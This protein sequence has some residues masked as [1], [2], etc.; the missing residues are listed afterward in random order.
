MSLFDS[1]T[2]VKVQE[3]TPQTPSLFDSITSVRQRDEDEYE[4]DLV[5]PENFSVSALAGSDDY[6]TKVR[7]Y[8]GN[9]LGEGGQQK[10]GEENKDYIERFLSHMR[11]FENNTIDL[12]QEMSYIY[13]ANDQERK[14]FA[15]AYDIYNSLPGMFSAGGGSVLSGLYDYTTLNVFDPANVVGLGVGTLAAKQ[16]AKQGVKGVLKGLAKRGNRYFNAGTVAGAAADGVVSAGMDA[17]LQNVM[18]ESGIQ[19]EYSAG[20]TA[21]AFGLGAVGSQAAQSGL[22]AVGSGLRAAT[23][24]ARTG[25]ASTANRDLQQE[26]QAARGDVTKKQKQQAKK[27][28]ETAKFEYDKARKLLDDIVETRYFDDELDPLPTLREQPGETSATAGFTP[29]LSLEATEVITNVV[30]KIASET[31]RPLPGGPEVQIS[32][33]IF[34]ALQVDPI[35]DK[36][37]DLS[38]LDTSIIER[39]ISEA[40]MSP[41]EFAQVMRVSV[42]DAG[43]TLQK[44]SALAQRLKDIGGLTG[45]QASRIDKWFDVNK[46]R[47]QDALNPYQR[48]DRETRAF[49]VSGVATTVRNASTTG[50]MGSLEAG[51]RLVDGYVFA[52]F[53]ASNRESLTGQKFEYDHGEIVRDTFGMFA[54]L[55][56]RNFT[57]QV[58]EATL[59]D[60]PRLLNQIQRSLTEIG[61]GELSKVSRV[62]NFLNTAHDSIVRRAVYTDSLDRNLRKTTGMDIAQTMAQN[63]RIPTKILQIAVDDALGATFAD[64]P[65]SGLAKAFVQMQEKLGFAPG[66]IAAPLTGNPM[67]ALAGTTITA[68][69]RFMVSALKMI[70]KYNLPG[71]AN[72]VRQIAKAGRDYKAGQLDKDAYGFALDKAYMDL[73]KG[74]LGTAAMGAATAYRAQNQDIR[75]YEMRNDDGTTTDIRPFFPLSPFL[76]LGDVLVKSG[77]SLGRQI[78]I[79]LGDGSV[80]DIKAG[81]VVEGLFGVRMV[82]GAAYSRDLIKRA[83][84]PEAVTDIMENFGNAVGEF[85]NRFNT[86][87]FSS[88]IRDFERQYDADLNVIRNSRIREDVQGAPIF[89]ESLVTSGTRGMPQTFR[90]AINEAI[91]GSDPIPNVTDSPPLFLGT[92]DRPMRY[93]APLQQQF[94]GMRMIERRNFIENELT[95][96]GIYSPFEYARNTRD[97]LLTQYMREMMGDIV[98]SMNLREDYDQLSEA[99]Q[100]VALMDALRIARQDA[101][102]QAEGKMEAEDPER[103]AKMKFYMYPAD[104]RKAVNDD[105]A[106]RNNGKTIEDNKD[107]DAGANEAY[108]K[109]RENE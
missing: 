108:F 18:I 46:V 80:T 84:D 6:M 51:A 40:G 30:E 77:G 16:F 9:R 63:G 68:F 10:D 11:S 74:T 56:D 87:L 72:G 38:D 61:D 96:L 92:R 19:D 101:L 34:A 24:K 37:L 3:D 70:G 33:K 62:V 48:I 99:N 45:D 90:S 58:V 50:I 41:L 36:A 17:G 22:A 4:P 76:L 7:A 97:A 75:F 21:A 102:I 67:L 69:P 26:I 105:Y 95:R 31:G 64:M 14:Q 39:V 82:G 59:G 53:K 23:S 15:E 2:S 35:N 42:A 86:N 47:V 79:D 44:Y 71:A 12:T 65:K 94:T 60:N 78:G 5:L 52:P 91:P 103:Y 8:M 55:A 100:R 25:T 54:N 85:V 81:D 43:K 49:V 88:F 73:A 32:D 66:V 98:S 28:E 109:D 27:T 29:E 57:M 107:W 106:A 1:I 93:Q 20:R 83:T 104:I 13:G 89:W